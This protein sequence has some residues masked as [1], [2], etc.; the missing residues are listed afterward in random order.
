MTSSLKS[1]LWQLFVLSN[2]IFNFPMAFSIGYLLL[3]HVV[4]SMY[5]TQE[6]VIFHVS[7][8]QRIPVPSL[9]ALNLMREIRLVI[10]TFFLVFKLAL[11]IKGEYIFFY[12][13][14]LVRWC[15]ITFCNYIFWFFF[16]LYGFCTHFS[17]Y[18]ACN[19]IE[20]HIHLGELVIQE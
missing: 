1:C 20:L 16:L 6:I 15:R 14:Y 13:V 11:S 18:W 3:I 4:L 8:S 19:R 7:H 17:Y 5:G 2:S 12:I 9:T 10:T